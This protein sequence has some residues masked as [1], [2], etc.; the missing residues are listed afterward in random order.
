MHIDDFLA[1]VYAELGK[2][3]ADCTNILLNHP[4]EHLHEANMTRGRIFGYADSM[5]T[6]K[7]L[8]DKITKP[9]SDI[10]IDNKGKVTNVSSR[11]DIY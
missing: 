2:K 10:E 5:H 1:L 4:Y 3:N 9:K 6:I 7:F 11:P 8:Y